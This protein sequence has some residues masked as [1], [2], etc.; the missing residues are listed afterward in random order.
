MMEQVLNGPKKICDDAPNNEAQTTVDRL[1]REY[2][3]G[4][5]PERHAH[6]S[7]QQSGEQG[8]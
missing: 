6:V 7:S 1:L 8:R 4:A 2:F 5:Y 3:S